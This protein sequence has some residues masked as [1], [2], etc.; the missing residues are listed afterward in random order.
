MLIDKEHTDRRQLIMFKG[1]THDAT[2][3]TKNK[4]STSIIT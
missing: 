3:V 2:N 4:Q 1:K